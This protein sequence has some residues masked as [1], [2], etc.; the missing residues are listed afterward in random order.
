MTVKELIAELNEMITNEE[1]TENARVRN[2]ENEDIF[3]IIDENNEVTI[4]F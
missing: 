2:A 3:S 1:I 4:Y